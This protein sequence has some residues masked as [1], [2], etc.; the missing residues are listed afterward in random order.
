MNAGFI[1]RQRSFSAITYTVYECIYFQL[2]ELCK[3]LVL[4]GVG[5]EKLY[6]SISF[7]KHTL[8]HKC[9]VFLAIPKNA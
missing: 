7:R 9:K 1:F 6:Y 5:P 4:S 3:S 2:L 8:E